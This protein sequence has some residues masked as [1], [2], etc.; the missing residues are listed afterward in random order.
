[1]S[2]LNSTRAATA[3]QVRRFLEQQ[4]F[5]VIK[6][7][8]PNEIV[9]GE[10]IL[11]DTLHV[12]VGVDGSLSVNW[13]ESEGFYG[14][15]PSYSLEQIAAELRARFTPKKT[16]DKLRT[17]ELLLGDTV[18]LASDPALGTMIVKNITCG[19]VTL[20]RPYPHAADFSYTGGV[21]CYVG[22]EEF[23]VFVNGG[24][25]WTWT[26]LNRKELK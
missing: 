18:Y 23:K 3:S 16:G 10:V 1:M 11:N 8:E 7:S 21:P 15:K 20:F 26:L 5:Q 14:S 24:D 25:E 17:S 6:H 9:D 4:G 19:E 13:R 12:Q 22:V 2:D